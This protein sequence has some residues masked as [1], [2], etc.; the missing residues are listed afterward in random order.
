M[1]RIAVFGR[2]FTSPGMISP[3]SFKSS[4]V[5]DAITSSLS[6]QLSSN[7]SQKGR[8]LY[9]F[10]QRSTSSNAS[11]VAWMNTLNFVLTTSVMSSHNSTVNSQ[12]KTGINIHFCQ[13]PQV[14]SNRV[15]S[16]DP[17]AS[18]V[19]RKRTFYIFLSILC[20]ISNSA[21]SFHFLFHSSW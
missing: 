19:S 6:H 18:P 10:N 17:F 15:H 4:F 8:R 5:I 12:S 1:T 7:N 11:I 13:K 9:S 2:I 16:F 21:Y 14:A 3:K 20:V